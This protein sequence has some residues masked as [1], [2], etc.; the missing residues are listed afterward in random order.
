[1][2][3]A[4]AAPPE[5][6]TVSSLQADPTGQA[7][8][9]PTIYK[10]ISNAVDLSVG[11]SA[12]LRFDEFK[13][14]IA[15]NSGGTSPNILSELE[16]DQ[17]LSHQLSMGGTLEVK[18]RFYCR[19]QG[20]IAWIQSGSVRDSDY[21][22]DDRTLEYSRSTS[23]TNGDEMYDLVVGAGYPIHL[24]RDRLFLAPLTGISYHV[25]NFRIT[26]GE[27]V[28]SDP[29]RTPPVGPLDSRLNSTYSAHWFG[30]WAGCD[31]RYLMETP[32]QE[33][34]PIVWELS[35]MYHFLGDYSAEADW[36][37]RGDL[38]HPKS[39]EHDAD[40]EGISLT[41]KCQIPIN[42]KVGIHFM[43]NYTRW[44]TDEG[45]AT[46]YETSGTSH[47]QLNDVEWETHSVMVG[48]DCLFF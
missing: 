14:S 3:V 19:G 43:A 44:T 7:N 29:P 24:L 16:W 47:T 12:G 23:E 27:Q 13:W 37:L 32:N 1:V 20:N 45:D 35:L 9:L 41:M 17:V 30:L 39:F 4:V 38:D 48:V 11:L 40:A 22:G 42:Q 6:E 8:E 21:D 10:R 26:N 34:P 28:I 31:L 5:T 25:Q 36:N 46:I 33:T 2:H 18:R 15:G